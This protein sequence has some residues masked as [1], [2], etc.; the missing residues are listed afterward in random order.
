MMRLFFL[1]SIILV[2]AS[3]GSSGYNA[4]PEPTLRSVSMGI[5]VDGVAGFAFAGESPFYVE[6]L[7]YVQVGSGETKSGDISKVEIDFGDGSGWEDVTAAWMSKQDQSIYSLE[8][9]AQPH[10]YTEP[11]E[12]SVHCRVTFTDNEVFVR[13]Q[14]TEPSYTVTITAPSA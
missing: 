1:M 14:A 12:Y 13:P 2:L 3:C 8:D 9:A 10:T 5:L 4:D 11:G 7:V 6:A